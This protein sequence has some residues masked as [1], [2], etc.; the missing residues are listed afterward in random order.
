MVC[1]LGLGWT[2]LGGLA[3][4]GLGGAANC[5]SLATA[6]LAFWPWLGLAVAKGLGA[7]LGVAEKISDRG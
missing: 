2:A 3:R 4:V 5:T 6:S 1:G 7:P